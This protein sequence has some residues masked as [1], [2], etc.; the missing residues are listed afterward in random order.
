MSKY[1]V[2]F[3]LVI[4]T[5]IL[6]NVSVY[7]LD[8]CC[9]SSRC[10]EICGGECCKI[11]FINIYSHNYINENLIISTLHDQQT[12]IQK[13]FCKSIFRPPRSFIQAI[14]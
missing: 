8:D 7:P 2:I 13:D 14:S 4:T 3:I 9:D 10:I 6:A 1:F 5:L 11:E 12:L